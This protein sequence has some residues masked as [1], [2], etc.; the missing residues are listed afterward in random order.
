MGVQQECSTLA[1]KWLYT[2]REGCPD[3]FCMKP[4]TS[5]MQALVDMTILIE[6]VLIDIRGIRQL[7]SIAVQS[8]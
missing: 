4:S 6:R 2:L 1:E 5:T 7:Q 8:L 3:R